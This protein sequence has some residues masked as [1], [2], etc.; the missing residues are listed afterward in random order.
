[1]KGEKK[2]KMETRVRW[3]LCSNA[4][5]TRVDN[6]VGFECIIGRISLH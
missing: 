1:M 4:P 2:K 3:G 5:L 6:R